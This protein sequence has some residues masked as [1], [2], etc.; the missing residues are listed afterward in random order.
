MKTDLFQ[1]CDH[2]WVF[3]ISWHIECSTL[4]A[5]SFRIWNSST[6]I[7]SPLLALF[8]MML[9]KAHW[10]SCSRMCGSR[11]VIAPP[12]LSGSWRSFLYNSSMWSLCKWSY[13]APFSVRVL[14]PKETMELPI[15]LAHLIYLLLRIVIDTFVL[16]LPLW[17]WFFLT[18]LFFPAL[19]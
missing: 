10:T 16:C 3:Q 2:C 19:F 11:W 13:K 5:S 6:G 17:I 14:L 18:F 7:P 1:S 12:L 4:T 8:V 9:P 15:Y